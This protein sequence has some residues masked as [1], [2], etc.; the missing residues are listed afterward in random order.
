MRLQTAPDTGSRPWIWE[1]D[2]C[3]CRWRPV[4]PA[5]NTF[6]LLSPVATSLLIVC[7]SSTSPARRSRH[8]VTLRPRNSARRFQRCVQSRGCCCTSTTGAC[9]Q[10]EK[11]LIIFAGCRAL[12]CRSSAAARFQ[13][14][15]PSFR[16]CAGIETLNSSDNNTRRP[17]L[18]R[19]YR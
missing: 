17:L 9:A 10:K 1:H 7:C 8:S 4:C 6:L 16:A 3:M 12:A 15:A 13:H 5:K 18:V 2:G 19:R 14:T 11:S